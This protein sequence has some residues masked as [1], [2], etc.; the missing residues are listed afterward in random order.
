M[1]IESIEKAY[2]L[3]KTYHLEKTKILHNQIPEDYY[4]F[5]LPFQV[6]CLEC[7]FT[8]ISN[9]QPFIEKLKEHE[10]EDYELVLR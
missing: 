10:H 8:L 3:L 5:L 7:Y 9:D 2:Q 6:R 1:N 4:I